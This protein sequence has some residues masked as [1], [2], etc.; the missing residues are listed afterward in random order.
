MGLW[1][2]AA[3][4]AQPLDFSGNK[5]FGVGCKEAEQTSAGDEVS[6]VGDV[7]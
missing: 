6:H 7:L 2:T 5:M 1:K 3:K 4:T